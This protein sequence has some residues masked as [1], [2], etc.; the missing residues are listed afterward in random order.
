MQFSSEHDSQD[1]MQYNDSEC[2]DIPHILRLLHGNWTGLYT[3]AEG[4]PAVLGQTTVGP[5]RVFAG[6]E[7]DSMV[8]GFN[9]EP[10]PEIHPHPQGS[11]N[12]NL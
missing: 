12:P 10:T 3:A 4:T 5:E 8:A 9:D 7:V 11:G 1:Q 6:G 2:I